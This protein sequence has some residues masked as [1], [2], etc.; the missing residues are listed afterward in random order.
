VVFI[1]TALYLA[2]GVYITETLTGINAIGHYTGLATGIILILTIKG[3]NY[4]KEQSG[5]ELGKA[6]S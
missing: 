4:E 2:Y 6:I 1:G 3:V 5:V